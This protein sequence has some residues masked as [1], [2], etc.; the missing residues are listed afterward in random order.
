ML[1]K[2]LA[3][4]NI[5]L[6]SHDVNF[7]N[8]KITITPKNLKI[9]KIHV[10]N[11]LKK[12]VEIY[13]R[14]ESQYK[15]QNQT[16]F[17]AR[18]DKQ[19]EDVEVF[20]GIEF[21]INLNSYQILTQSDIDN[22]DVRPQIGQQF[23]NRESKKIRGNFDETNSI[24]IYIHKTSELHGSSYVKTPLRTSAILNNGNDDE[25]C[26]LWSISAHIVASSWK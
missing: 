24:T 19:D 10:I 6:D 17:W 21:N 18:F 7:L 9:E 22:I 11:I 1:K 25:Y 3:S 16:A 15:F 13:A 5:I 20:D 8:L 26:F 23:Q 14:L 4:K 12:M 2:W